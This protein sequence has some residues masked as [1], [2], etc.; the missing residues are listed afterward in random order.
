MTATACPVCADVLPAGALKCKG[1][2]ALRSW[3]A[4]C[5]SCGTPLPEQATVC[6]ECGRF[7]R[8]GRMCASCKQPLSPDA[9]SCG[10]CGALQWFGG[11]LHMSSST[12]SLIV[13][14]ITS[15]TALGAVAANMKPFAR[16]DPRVFFQAIAPNNE[17]EPT[18]EERRFCLTVFNSGNRPA[19][20]LDASLLLKGGKG[21][22]KLPVRIVEP[23]VNQRLVPGGESLTIELEVPDWNPKD[24][25]IPSRQ[26]PGFKKFLR[27]AHSLELRLFEEGKEAEATNIEGIPPSMLPALLCRAAQGSASETDD[28]CRELS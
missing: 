18:E 21:E 14:L 27:K 19:G 22:K 10:S 5:E 17:L 20:V 16:S 8:N 26:D 24:F 4:L 25:S 28:P 2:G 3:L 23:P 13:A 11:H 6:H 9:R 15:I 12:L 1:C 7:P